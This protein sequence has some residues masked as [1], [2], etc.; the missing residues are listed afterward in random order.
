MSKDIIY[1][2]TCK[3]LLPAIL[4]K[5]YLSLTTSNFS[6]EKLNM[7]PVVWL[8]TSPTPENMGLLFENNMPDYLNKTHI[9]IKIRKKPYMKLWDEWSDEKG[10]DK[11]LK[12]M[13]IESAS[14][15]DAYK[16]W[17]ISEKIITINEIIVIENLKT[18]EVY[19]KK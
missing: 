5:R 16:T 2:F 3:F 19:Y 15:E 7:F 8:T 12:K 6:I 14:A 11:R 9:R 4:Q 10:M 17:Y 13:M 18:G 1:H